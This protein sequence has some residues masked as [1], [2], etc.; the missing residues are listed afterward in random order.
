MDEMSKNE[1]NMP[2]TNIVK[3]RNYNPSSEI[4]YETAKRLLSN[5]TFLRDELRILNN[6]TL[7]KK[8]DL[9]G[10][11][12]D[13]NL[14]AAENELKSTID[15]RKVSESKHSGD[16]E[17]TRQLQEKE[18]E[19]AN[20]KSERDRIASELSQLLSSI[21]TESVLNKEIRT[22]Y[23]DHYQRQTSPQLK[24]LQQKARALQ[25]V[26]AKT[27]SDSVPI[28]EQPTMRLAN[29]SEQLQ[30]QKSKSKKTEVAEKKRKDKTEGL[31]EQ[32][33]AKMQGKK[34]RKMKVS[35]R[36]G[37]KHNASKKHRKSKKW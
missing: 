31:D 23:K 5:V 32:E 9:I 37:R 1:M 13:A 18:K 22:L 4:N 36:K 12:A 16:D 29:L 28:M 11:F 7:D 20:A 21:N 19:L 10:K 25:E 14:I 17:F 15:M 8:L 35:K 3:E 6:P 30:N 24:E 33:Q 34:Y 2:L 27:R 26:A